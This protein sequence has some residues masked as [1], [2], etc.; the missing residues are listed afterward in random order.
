MAVACPEC[1]TP[2]RPDA[3]S[4]DDCGHVLASTSG[5]YVTLQFPVEHPVVEVS[6]LDA[7]A[8]AAPPVLMP[9]PP[10]T[11]EQPALSS[12][13]PD[14]RRAQ[15]KKAAAVVGAIAAVVAVVLTITLVASTDN[16]SPVTSMDGVRDPETTT[17]GSGTTQ[18]AAPAPA[19]SLAPTDEISAKRM[20]E[21][22]A[23][24]DH[25]QVEALT[26]YWVPQLSSKRLGLVVRG[27]TYDYQAI[28]ADFTSL[29]RKYPGA[30][31][32]WSGDYSSFRVKD[33]WVTIVPD[34][35]G[36]GESANS[37]CDVQGIGKDDCYAKR[38]THTG[39]HAENTLLRK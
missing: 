15:Q 10:A 13:E 6:P 3:S 4:C 11:D 36:A 34:S 14:Q 5:G 32:L 23:A 19:T 18:D 7:Q 35:F 16:G 17:T 30:L 28:W 1:G 27:T 24:E 26:G 37:W 31:L 33:F 29:R 21:D 20:L 25:A 39:G 12:E 2:V 8:P 22:T 38:I 9:G